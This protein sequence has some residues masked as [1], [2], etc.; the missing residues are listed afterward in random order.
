M[1]RDQRVPPRRTWEYWTIPE[2]FAMLQR[3]LTG[4][5]QQLFGVAERSQVIL[6]A[7]FD[8]QTGYPRRY[9]RQVLGADQE[10]H[11]EIVKFEVVE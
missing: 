9:R 10:I 3:E 7:E 6:H 8:P 4:E 5:P 2:Q 1:K 11:W